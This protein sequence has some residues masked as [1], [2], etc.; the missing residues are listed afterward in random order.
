MDTEEAA[1]TFLGFREGILHNVLSAG[2]MLVGHV[3][4]KPRLLARSAILA[5]GA[6]GTRCGHESTKYA[7]R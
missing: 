6:L 2:G 3:G 4:A 1:P 5:T 7:R